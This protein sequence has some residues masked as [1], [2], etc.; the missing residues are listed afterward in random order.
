MFFTHVTS[1]VPGTQLFRL[2]TPWP[3]GHRVHF[4]LFENG[5]SQIWGKLWTLTSEKGAHTLTRWGCVE[6]FRRLLRACQLM[7]PHQ[8]THV[9]HTEGNYRGTWETESLPGQLCAHYNRGR[10]GGLFPKGTQGA[11][12]GFGEHLAISAANY[13]K[14]LVPT[15]Q[16]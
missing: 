2:N 1:G 15:E 4:N 14:T 6:G 7:T 8:L 12:N 10:S 16:I 13:L 11:E 3:L 9:I 5:G